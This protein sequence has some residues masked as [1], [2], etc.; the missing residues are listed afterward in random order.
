MMR[1]SS[2]CP[3][4][5]REVALDATIDSTPFKQQVLENS[6]LF[7]RAAEASPDRNLTFSVVM[8]FFP[9]LVMREIILSRATFMEWLS[10]FGGQLS[11]FIGASVITMLET[12]VF[13]TRF[14]VL[15]GRKVVGVMCKESGEEEEEGL[16]KEGELV[17][18]GEWKEGMGRRRVGNAAQVAPFRT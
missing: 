1:A 13:M 7:G 9:N 18:V 5:C 12:L 6:L 16:G 11:L 2:P 4:K 17:K 8:V 10:A 15:A 3:T 14:G